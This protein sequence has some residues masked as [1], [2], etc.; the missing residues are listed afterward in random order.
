[1]DSTKPDYSA[2]LHNT[3]LRRKEHKTTV[4]FP[5]GTFFILNQGHCHGSFLRLVTSTEAKG[6][7]SPDICFQFRNY[8]FK[9]VLS[10]GPLMVI[11]FFHFVFPGIFTNFYVETVSM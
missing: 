4:Q 11:T 1:V 6:A 9:S 2:V 7:V 5:I 10:A 3:S 8:K